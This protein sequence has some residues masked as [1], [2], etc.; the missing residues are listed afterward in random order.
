MKLWN[1]EEPNKQYEL[2]SM[3][4]HIGSGPG[5]GHYVSIIKSEDKWFLFN[6]NEVKMISESEIESYFGTTDNKP[7]AC[8]Y[9][10]FYRQ[11]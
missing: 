5:M 3:V 11:I 8:A 4:I 9:L 1:T 10:L 2:N 6:D 7:T